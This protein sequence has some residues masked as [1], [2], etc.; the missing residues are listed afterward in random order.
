M[1]VLIIKVKDKIFDT[2]YADL[3]QL[4]AHQAHHEQATRRAFGNLLDHFAKKAGWTLILEQRMPNGCIPD[5]TL[6][7]LYLPHGYWE[8]KDTKDD[9]RAEIK[10]KTSKGYPTKNIV[11]EDTQ[12]AILIQNGKEVGEYDLRRRE[13]LV[14]LLSAFLNFEEPN[15]QNFYVAVREFG[16][17][18]PLSRPWR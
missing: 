18:I 14:N 12:R 4:S 7:D 16:E 1:P 8:A 5:G 15:Y 3:E 6:R 9:L 13:E 2:Y 10:R 11:Y 17:Q